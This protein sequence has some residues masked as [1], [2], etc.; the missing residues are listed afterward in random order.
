MSFKFSLVFVVAINLSLVFLF[1]WLSHRYHWD[2]ESMRLKDVALSDPEDLKMLGA[3]LAVIVSQ[4]VFTLL[5][6]SVKRTHFYVSD[7][8]KI[9]ERLDLPRHRGATIGKPSRVHH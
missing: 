2:I 3:F 9:M 5:L 7:L 1:F 6:F 8:N 4:F